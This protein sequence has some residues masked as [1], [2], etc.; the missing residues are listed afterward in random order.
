[1]G[2]ADLCG[3]VGHR[4]GSAVWAEA[5]QPG[6]LGTGSLEEGLPFSPL[7]HGSE[8]KQTKC[9]WQ[10]GRQLTSR[11]PC[12]GSVPRPL[13]DPST[14]PP[15]SRSAGS[16]ASALRTPQPRA[17]RGAAL[18][19]ATLVEGPPWSCAG[20][21][22]SLWASPTWVGWRVAL[23]GRNK[24]SGCRHSRGTGGPTREPPGDCRDRGPGFPHDPSLGGGGRGSPHSAIWGAQFFGPWPGLRARGTQAPPARSCAGEG[25]VW[26]ERQQP[27]VVAALPL[28]TQTR[29]KRGKLPSHG[30]LCRDVSK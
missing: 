2:A 10:V 7:T 17:A 26:G 21:S 5:T 22:P 16:Q 23:P 13:G 11:A 9:L 4:L 3:L 27:V 1:M 20:E 8:A 18:P 15:G 28:H 30:W 12:L 14:Q 19:P 29:E 6:P 25:C 24:G